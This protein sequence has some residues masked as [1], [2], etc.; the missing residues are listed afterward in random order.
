MDSEQVEPGAPPEADDAGVRFRPE[1]ARSTAPGLGRPLT[2]LKRAV[3]RLI[4]QPLDDIAA[5]AGTGVTD[6]LAEARAAAVAAREGREWATAALAAEAAEREGAQRGLGEL[7]HRIEAIEQALE[8]LQAPARLARLERSQRTALR[9]GPGPERAPAPGGSPSH[10]GGPPIDYLA[11]EARFRGSEEAIGERQ[12][13]YRELL[14]GRRRVV[15]LGCGR[16]ELV[17]L[18][19]VSGITAYGVDSNADF[20]ALVAE[21]GLEVVHQDLVP[22]L[23][24]LGP[25]DVDAIVLSHVVEH[26][27]PDVLSRLVEAAWERLP[28]GGLLVMETPNPESLVAGSVNFHRDPTHLRP[29]HP[30]TLAFICESTGFASVEIRRLSPV[31]EADRLPAPAPGEGPLSEHLD[32]VVGRLNDLLYGFQDYAVVARR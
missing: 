18:L 10:P 17:R 31:P 24:G 12:A 14:A 29:V 5:Q 11:F 25:G 6:A 13:A 27:P 15:D 8:K 4:R 1:L 9:P 32:R 26:L 20:V 2:A 28:E 19:T 30:D 7:M 21:K 23:E 3:A 22:H 16:G